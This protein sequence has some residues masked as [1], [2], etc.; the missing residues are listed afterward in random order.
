MPDQLRRKFDDMSSHM[1][2]IEYH[3]T[4]GYKIFDLVNKQFMIKRDVILYE[5]KERD[6][7]D[8]VKKDSTRVLSDEPAFATQKN[9]E[10]LLKFICSK[11]KGKYR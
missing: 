2:L 10:S 7:N 9:T 4:S 1:L 8:N 11:R 6:W 5:L 3:L